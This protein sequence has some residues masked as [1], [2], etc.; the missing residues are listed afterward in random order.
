MTGMTK[1]VPKEQRDGRKKGFWALLSGAFA[2]PAVPL[3]PKV[4]SLGALLY[5]IFPL[6]FIPDLIPF[7]YGDDFL[8]LIAGVRALLS[9][10]AR[11]RANLARR[12]KDGPDEQ[13]PVIDI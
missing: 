2:D 10:V 5:L 1:T 6:D 11:H 4:V 13:G 3:S 12:D 7:G 8:I 9:V